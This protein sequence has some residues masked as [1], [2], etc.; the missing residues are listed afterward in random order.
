[1]RFLFWFNSIFIIIHDQSVIHS[2]FVCA[3]WSYYPIYLSHTEFTIKF[4][5]LISLV[6]S[7]TYVT[8]YHVTVLFQVII[9]LSTHTTSYNICINKSFSKFSISSIFKLKVGNQ[10]FYKKKNIPPN[11]RKKNYDF[12]IRS[13]DITVNLN[14][15]QK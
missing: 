10:S 8:N 3:W 9:H 15:K 12:V 5:S 6:K 11:I 4:S 14:K 1:M 7:F 13:A 2:I